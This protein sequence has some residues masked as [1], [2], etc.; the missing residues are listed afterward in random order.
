M[1]LA[2]QKR[3]F[4]VTNLPG[5][6]DFLLSRKTCLK[7]CIQNLVSLLFQSDERRL[8]I[9]YKSWVFQFPNWDLSC[10]HLHLR[11]CL[12]ILGWAGTEGCC[13]GRQG[14]M[15]RCFSL[16]GCAKE[17]DNALIQP[18]F[19]ENQRKEEMLHRKISGLKFSFWGFLVQFHF[20]LRIHWKKKRCLQTFNALCN[21]QNVSSI[22]HQTKVIEECFSRLQGRVGLH[23]LR[24]SGVVWLESEKRDAMGEH[25][26]EG[27]ITTRLTMV[28][29]CSIQCLFCIWISY[30]RISWII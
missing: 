4:N 7:S 28:T 18:W 14:A 21:K 3:F 30:T 12:S 29:V 23:W 22:W 6:H 17:K 11:Q 26:V 10:L 13:S 27:T 24:C 25:V 5:S 16:Q 20:S 19:V 15:Y 9:F 1:H 2:L 8:L